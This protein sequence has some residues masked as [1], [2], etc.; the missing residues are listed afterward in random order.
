MQYRYLGK[1]GLKVSEIGLGTNQFG[2][3]VSSKEAANIIHGAIDA[4]VNFIDTADIYQNGNSEESIGAALKGR[5]QGAV[6]AT[7]VHNA[8]EPRGPND[9][10]SSRQH[11]FQGV[12]ASLRRLQSDTIDLYQLHN[13]DEHTPIIETMRALDDLIRVGK[14]RYIGASNFN[15][16]QLTEAN[17]V[18]RQNGW[19]EFIS[20]QPHYH[21]LERSIEDE[22]LSACV[23][24]NIGVLPYFPLAGGFLTGKYLEGKAAPKGSRGENSPYVQKYM[25][26]EN[27][28]LL[29]QLT[30]LAESHGRRLNA[31]AH[32]WLLAQGQ[33]SSVISGAT[34]VDQVLSN[35]SAQDWK[36]SGEDLAAVN[37]LLNKSDAHD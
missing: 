37:E 19:T 1:S 7:K 35:I 2:G 33:I 13:W 5:R 3:K 4:G 20:I 30:N 11:I 34:S 28:A 14:V 21:M 25:T 12:D 6:I 31:L 29:D 24:F 36:L 26:S 10:G 22:L 17:A 27:F 16:W 18:A 15:A 23:Y 32:A 8:V 9:R